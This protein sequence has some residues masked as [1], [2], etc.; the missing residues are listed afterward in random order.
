MRTYLTIW[1]SSEG[2]S[3][4]TIVQNLKPLG[5]EAMQGNYDFFYKW[6]G[7]PPVDELMRLGNSV[8]KILNGSKVT[9]KMETV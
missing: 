3:P 4:L 9:F 5:F 1:F 8:Q 7:K 2:A 6:D